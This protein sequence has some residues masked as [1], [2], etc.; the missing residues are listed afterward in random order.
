MIDLLG[1]LRRIMNMDANETFDQATDSLEAIK[2]FLSPGGMGSPRLYYYGVVTNVPGANQFDIS[3]F[4]GIF[5][6]TYFNGYTVYVLR[7][8]GG[9][10]G[11]PQSEFA[12]ITIY[13]DATASFTH[14][15]ILTAAIGVGDEVII[16]HPSIYG[17]LIEIFKDKIWFD[18]ILGVV[19]TAYPTGSAL[20][21]SNTIADVITLCARYNIRHINVRGTLVLGVAMTAYRFEGYK[22]LDI[23]H[24]VDLNGQDVSVSSFH[25]LIVTGAQGGAGLVACDDCILLSATGF[26]G[27]ATNCGLVT[28]L[29]LVAATSS[30]FIDCYSYLGACTINLGT[31]TVANFVNL[32]GSF[33]LANQTAGTTNIWAANGCELTI[34]ASCTG[35]TI[36][37][38]GNA[39]V[40]GAGGGVTINDYTINMVPG[41]DSAVTTQMRD[42]IGSKADTAL[43]APTAADSMMRYIKGIL[44][45]TVGTASERVIGKLQMAATTIDLNQA[46]GSYDLFTGTT[47]DVVVERLVIRT[48]NIVAGGALTSISIQT[49]DATPQIFIDAADGV[50]A[51]LTAEAQLGYVGIALIKT[52][53]KIQ[54][55]IAG[56]AHGAAYVCDVIAE[57]RAIVTGGYLT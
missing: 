4:I 1:E 37:I 39:I 46:A 43:A 29:T 50:V 2:D 14:E 35:G 18:S 23:A 21:P 28:A 32:T 25:R 19:G 40:T 51:N 12:R 38:Y 20:R 15:A 10:G 33:V 55:T 7:D 26:N 52:G 48:P 13:A 8:A 11:A 3:A 27:V 24:T 53:T 6:D 42:V 22:H 17:A 44:E 36:N 45:G 57:Y 9:V 5:G 31:P 47:Q 41:V 16:I 34:A 54:L 30:G 56:G 49:D